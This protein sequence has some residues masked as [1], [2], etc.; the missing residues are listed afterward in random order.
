MQGEEEEQAQE[1]H[2]AH[3]TCNVTRHTSHV[4][5]WSVRMLD[6]MALVNASNITE[7]MKAGLFVSTPDTGSGFRV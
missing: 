1:D 7:N 5:W 2:S 6:N 4:T 3:H